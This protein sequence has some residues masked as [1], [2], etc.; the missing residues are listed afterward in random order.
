MLDGSTVRH[1]MEVAFIINRKDWRTII[2]RRE[3]NREN[4]LSQTGEKELIDQRWKKDGG[5]I[6][7]LIEWGLDGLTVL[8]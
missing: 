6:W 7:S 8:S 2:E 1:I 4:V 5:E 3:F